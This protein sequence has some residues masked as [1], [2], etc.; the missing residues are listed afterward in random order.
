MLKIKS[1]GKAIAERINP[2]YTV[3]EKL[4]KKPLKKHPKT[5]IICPDFKVR[6]P[7]GKFLTLEQQEETYK[8]TVQ[9]FCTT[10][11]EATLMLNHMITC[12]KKE[13]VAGK[14]VFWLH[15]VNYGNISK[16]GVIQTNLTYTFMLRQLKPKEIKEIKLTE[17]NNG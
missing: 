2:S 1:L 3:W 11:K 7:R 15:A 17:E 12:G 5:Y 14:F 10:R 13:V 4:P 8:F 9:M 6:L 16:A